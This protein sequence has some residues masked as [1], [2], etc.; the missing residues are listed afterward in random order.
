M[1]TVF[2]SVVLLS[3]WGDCCKTSSNVDLE[4][5]K[6]TEII[7]NL[8]YELY[9]NKEYLR[10]VKEEHEINLNEEIELNNEKKKVIGDLEEKIKELEYDLYQNR[11]NHRNIE[12]NYVNMNKEI[13]LNNEQKK[14]IIRDL[15][16]KINEKKEKLEKEKELNN[17]Q[18]K[19]IRDLEEKINEKKI[20][21]VK[22]NSI[23]ESKKNAED[24]Q[25]TRDKNFK[26]LIN[27]QMEYQ[28]LDLISSKNFS[29]GLSSVINF[30]NQHIIFTSIGGD[31]FSWNHQDIKDKGQVIKNAKPVNKEF[32][33]Y[34]YSVV[35]T[36]DER[37][38]C[39]RADGYI[40][41]FN[42]FITNMSIHGLWKEES[43]DVLCL[44]TYRGDRLASCSGIKIFIWDINTWLTDS[45]KYRKISTLYGH[46]ETVR[47]ITVL[48][49]DRLASGS[50]DSTIKIW[51]L[52]NGEEILTLKG[53][54]SIVHS[55]L[56]LPNNKLAS[57]SKDKSII[58]WDIKNK[59]KVSVI[60][61][62]D[63]IVFCLILLKDNMTIASASFDK[64]IKIWD[65]ETGILL[66]KLNG[67]TNKVLS[68]V[69][70]NN[71]LFSVSLDKTLKDW[72]DFTHVGQNL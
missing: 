14:I 45:K 57:G 70:M 49:G 23:I 33:S 37:L 54:S 19:T 11:E 27:R 3:F 39:G 35:I 61:G 24:Q 9:Q 59:E 51:S 52:N 2:L 31:I 58:I 5:S 17:E 22:L 65:I 66:N 26:N 56:E 64:T 18:N 41:F 43:K 48:E 68:I 55:L 62:H 47:S 72:S 12:N 16:E 28:K 32:Q 15:E 42:S 36:K 8:K 7:K 21:I 25:L 30:K 46:S 13:K 53:H 44:A 60:K 71:H 40:H 6:T 50:I 29:H 63:D 67:H 69:T 20:E 38:F 1:R 34:I 4:N 10:N